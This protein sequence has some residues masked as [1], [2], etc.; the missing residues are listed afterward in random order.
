MHILDTLREW[1]WQASHDLLAACCGPRQADA[2]SQTE[3]SVV[4]VY[5]VV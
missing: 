1:L 2:A 5:R 3:I 4:H